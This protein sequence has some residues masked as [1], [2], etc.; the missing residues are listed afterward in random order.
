M[1]HLIY[2]FLD[3]IGN[4][5]IPQQFGDERLIDKIQIYRMNWLQHVGRM[6][7]E[8]IPEST[9]GVQ[10]SRTNTWKTKEVLEGPTSYW[11]QIESKCP[12]LEFHEYDDIT[13]MS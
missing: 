4:Q 2:I 1:N 3:H 10:T 5:D 8:R 13:Q 12:N 11:N 7:A 9:M 6:D